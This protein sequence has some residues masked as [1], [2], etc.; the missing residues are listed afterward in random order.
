MN[1]LTEEQSLKEPD[2]VK[3]ADDLR[4]EVKKWKEL[5]QSISKNFTN[6]CKPCNNYFHSKRRIGYCTECGGECIAP[7]SVNL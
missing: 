6:W 1:I 5:Y 2:Y 3:I 4:E 7:A